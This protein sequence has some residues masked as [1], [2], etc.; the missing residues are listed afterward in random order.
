MNRVAF[1][2]VIYWHCDIIPVLLY[3]GP[4]LVRLPLRE[5]LKEGWSLI[6]DSI[7]YKNRRNQ[8]LVNVKK[9]LIWK[10]WIGLKRGVPLIR[11]IQ[12]LHVWTSTSNGSI[13]A[14]VYRTYD[15]IWETWQKPMII[16]WKHCCLL[17]SPQAHVHSISFWKLSLLLAGARVGTRSGGSTSYAWLYW[18]RDTYVPVL[19]RVGKYER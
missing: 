2:I 6:R 1:G 18:R 19:L 9:G 5:V 10:C 14:H 7:K 12:R 16:K 3:S 11:R 4:P 13:F 15:H 17:L 8:F